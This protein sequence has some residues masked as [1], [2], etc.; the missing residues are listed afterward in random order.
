[1]R[2]C[3]SGGA[4]DTPIATVSLLMATLCITCLWAM[5]GGARGT[6]G[7]LAFRVAVP[8]GTPPS[9][10]LAGIA[11]EP[12]TMPGSIQAGA[13]GHA[14]ASVVIVGQ[15]YVGVAVTVGV[16]AR[17]RTRMAVTA[18]TADSIGSLPRL[19]VR[20]HNAGRHPPRSGRRPP[21]LVGNR[22]RPG[23]GRNRRHRPRRRRRLRPACHRNSRLGRRPAGDRRCDPH[24]LVVATG[25]VLQAS[26]PCRQHG[27]V[28]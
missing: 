7:D 17:L 15:V 28:G 27:T 6:I 4:S 14:S 13:N 22:Q 8:P 24:H 5:Q 10:Y 2:S 3:L 23:G 12:A 19:N 20:V 25:P 11:A 18:V 1:V 21:Y 9:Q 26:T 16:P